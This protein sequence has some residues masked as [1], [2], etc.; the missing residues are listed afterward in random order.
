MPTRQRILG[1]LVTLM[2]AVVAV[3]CCCL[4]ARAMAA[5]HP[6]HSCCD[7]PVEHGPKCPGNDAPGDGCPII[8]LRQQ[9][10][11]VSPTVLATPIDL[12]TPLADWLTPAAV[13][14]EPTVYA[15]EESALPATG[16]PTL[17]NLHTS[18]LW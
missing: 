15:R 2:M 8:K 10:P 13:V 17:L 18:L 16:P 12:A 6:R 9:M 5:D 3:W 11:S 7:V 1:G 4:P 14:V